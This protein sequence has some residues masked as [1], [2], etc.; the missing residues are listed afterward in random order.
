MK[1]LAAEKAVEYIEDGMVVGLG[2][3]STVE[4]A[5]KKL[6]ELVKNGLR[7]TGIP[8]SMHTRKVARDWNIPLSTLE[9]NPEIDLTIDGADE[10]D[11]NLNL[12]KGGG[13][14][15]TREKIIAYHSKRKI[16]VVDETKIVKA[17]GVD[18]PLPVEVI[19]YGWSSTK[20]ILE[21]FGCLVEIRRIM[22]DPYLTDNSHYILD[23]DF[24]RIDEPEQLEKDLN[25]IPGVV[26]NGLFIG[27]VD[28]VIVG[29]KQG[30]MTLEKELTI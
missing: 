2:T 11:A 19:K 9:E 12:I 4:Y 25:N 20:T 22:N 15:L 27:L 6:G 24:K 28:E 29:S 16:V 13:G 8:T 1:K 14:A 18:C 23:C 30:I 7:I 10:V 3:G 21:K 17:L 5:L 26:E